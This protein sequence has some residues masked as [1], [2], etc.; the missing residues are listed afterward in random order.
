MATGCASFPDMINVLFGKTAQK[1]TRTPIWVYKPD[2]RITVGGG[3]FSGFAVSVLFEEVDIDVWS[4]IDIDRVEISSCSR[5][6]VC[7]YKGGELSCDKSRFDVSHD[8]FQNPGRHMV[9][10]YRP[11][12]MEKE[13]SCSNLM[14]SVYNKNTLAS[15]GFV[16]LRDNPDANFAAQFTCNAVDWNYRGVSACSAKAGTYQEI[17]FAEPIDDWKA[18]STCG[19]V[20]KSA[21]KFQFQPEVGWCRASFMKDK[22][23]HDVLLNA[24]DEVLIR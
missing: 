5:H 3:T 9:Y 21:L 2:L 18:D 15:W 6:D 8:W 13:D 12:S 24:Y 19:M 17:V 4:P 14:I 11:D 20:K 16:F 22:K 23:F 7:Q 10:H 1:I